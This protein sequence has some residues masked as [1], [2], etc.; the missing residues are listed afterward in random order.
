MATLEAIPVLIAAGLLGVQYFLSGKMANE[1]GVEAAR[2]ELKDI[3]RKQGR[4]TAK[5][6]TNTDSEVMDMLRRMNDNMSTKGMAS[7]DVG[8]LDDDFVNTCKKLTKVL[9][10]LFDSNADGRLTS[11]EIE[12]MQG[13][14]RTLK[15]LG[16]LRDDGAEQLR[17][18]YKEH[19]DALG[20]T[21]ISSDA[22]KA[23][24]LKAGVRPEI[25]RY[26]DGSTQAHLLSHGTVVGLAGVSDRMIDG[27]INLVAAILRKQPPGLPRHADYKAIKSE[28]EAIK[29]KIAAA[30]TAASVGGGASGRKRKASAMSG[31]DREMVMYDPGSRTAVPF[32]PGSA[33]AAGTAM[34]VAVTAQNK[35]TGVFQRLAALIEQDGISSPD[36]GRVPGPDGY[37]FEQFLE[38]L[39]AGRARK[40]D[41][42]Q[43][44]LSFIR[45]CESNASTQTHSTLDADGPDPGRDESTD[46]GTDALEQAVDELGEAV[47]ID[48]ADDMAGFIQFLAGKLTNHDGHDLDALKR[49]LAE[50]LKK[51]P[52]TSAAAEAEPDAERL[53]AEIT[54]L[55]AKLDRANEAKNRPTPSKETQTEPDAATDGDAIAEL[56]LKVTEAEEPDPAT[57]GDL[58]SQIQDLK[59]QLQADQA[60]KQDAEQRL[61]AANSAAAL[62][63]CESQITQKQEECNGKLEDLRKQI[64]TLQ[65]QLENASTSAQD[66][67]GLQTRLN[68]CEKEKREIEGLKTKIQ[69]LQQRLEDFKNAGPKPD[70]KWNALIPVIEAAAD[71]GTGDGSNS[72]DDISTPLKDIV[73]KLKE[74][75]ACREQLAQKE[76]IINTLKSTILTSN[77]E[78]TELTKKLQEAQ[79]KLIEA[80]TA[81]DTNTST[82]ENLRRQVDDAKKNLE[83]ELKKYKLCGDNVEELRQRLDDTSA[84]LREKGDAYATLSAELEKIKE[85]GDARLRDEASKI[86]DLTDQIAELTNQTET[87]Q[88]EIKR[89]TEKAQRLAASNS[90]CETELAAAK[91]ELEELRAQSGQEA[92]C[93][94]QLQ[95][96]AD[97]PSADAGDM[98]KR[99]IQLV[100][101]LMMKQ[102]EVKS[103]QAVQTAD[104]KRIEQL[105]SEIAD[106]EKRLTEALNAVTNAPDHSEL[107]QNLDEVSQ[108]LNTAA[109]E[110]TELENYLN[111]LNDIIDDL[112]ARLD[113]ADTASKAKIAE[114]VSKIQKLETVIDE[115]NTDNG[116]LQKTIKNLQQEG[117]ELTKKLQ[118][119]EADCQRQL[120]E[121]RAELEQLQAE[122]TDEAATTPVE[123]ITEQLQDLQPVEDV[124]LRDELEKLKK[125]LE[126]HKTVNEEQADEIKQLKGQLENLNQTNEDNQSLK[127]DI[128]RL[129]NALKTERRDRDEA[130]KRTEE[131]I[132]KL[133]TQIVQSDA[134]KNE[135]QQALEALKKIHAELEK[136]SKQE[137]EEL[138]EKLKGLQATIALNGHDLQ[139]LQSELDE[140][141]KKRS[142]SI[143]L[144]LAALKHVKLKSKEEQDKL[145]NIIAALER[146][147]DLPDPLEPL[148]D[149]IDV[150]T[151]VTDQATQHAE[152]NE[153]AVTLPSQ[154]TMDL[155]NKLLGIF[156][157]KEADLELLLS[158]LADLLPRSEDLNG[159]VNKVKRCLDGTGGLDFNLPAG[160]DPQAFQQ[161]IQSILDAGHTDLEWLMQNGPV[162]AA[163]SLST[164]PIEDLRTCTLTKTPKPRSSNNTRATRFET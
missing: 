23:R 75:L 76:E 132:E 144:L 160:V 131:E 158:T 146:N 13:V 7:V 109:T 26:L 121:L 153:Y 59:Q 74:S 4:V 88:N 32:Q 114:Y 8:Q 107:Q 122:S 102:A 38:K 113:Q 69:E 2:V 128:A 101:Q 28:L 90:D 139:T 44:V 63:D 3:M 84:K 73:Q 140:L 93:L 163:Q 49:R 17:R 157:G 50:C 22:D 156:E 152:T 82:I 55:K 6:S 65:Q 34:A 19:V 149:M 11:S 41:T 108:Q 150:E 67:E 15:D 143:T 124:G 48:N 81:S 27:A 134:D 117:L 10:E 112:R 100:A 142:V 46:T 61:S 135:K 45:E 77:E 79:K 138:N 110:N 155:L 43:A 99:I 145:Q 78:I 92:A 9:K 129:R 54:E 62:S 162:L 21:Y 40:F 68:E 136:K 37:L 151:E 25:A 147:E 57:D 80:Q 66:A 52:T 29:A 115:K 83:E 20:R 127:N 105:Q 116:E 35:V 5:L 85:L 120:A 31:G 98:R 71:L 39:N 94:E 103:L 56:G 53:Q 130:K 125:E 51:P 137:L 126:Q 91:Q 33:G 119:A 30:R 87:D 148:L 1:S 141:K 97:Q 86:L 18:F 118:K 111:K 159:A 133:K 58:Q 96:Q 106:L 24:F 95:E 42:E 161:A 64:A 47:G 16:L 60:G 36:S 154:K 72:T 164:T 70:S 123:E 12:R 14:L 89:L 104:T